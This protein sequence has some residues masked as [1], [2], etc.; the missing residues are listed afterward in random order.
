MKTDEQE[1]DEATTSERRRQQ[2]PMTRHRG[3]SN[4]NDSRASTTTGN[5]RSYYA[6]SLS[7]HGQLL[8]YVVSTWCSWP[9]K[10]L[11]ITARPERR[12]QR[13]DGPTSPRSSER[14]RKTESS[15]TNTTR[16]IV[17]LWTTR[18]W[19]GLTIACVLF[20]V[21]A[22]AVERSVVAILAGI[23]ALGLAPVVYVRQQKLQRLDGTYICTNTYFGCAR[24]A[25]AGC[26]IFCSR[27]LRVS[28]L[29]QQQQQQPSLSSIIALRRVQN[30]LRQQVTR[31]HQ[32]N[33]RLSSQVRQ[34][35]R[36]VDR[37]VRTVS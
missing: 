34:L 35:D 21:M 14:T 2:R 36:Q 23:V 37:C 19:F 6:R 3:P 32:E 11:V 22:M 25:D 24:A 9:G 4:Q 29:P 12:Q 17:D 10:V 26:F 5:S 15:T 30:Q 33:D 27:S 20:H 18:L 28:F 8:T 31:L 16:Q 7:K 13:P 1:A